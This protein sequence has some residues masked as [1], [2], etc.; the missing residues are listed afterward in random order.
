MVQE[1]GTLEGER[2]NVIELKFLRNGN[3]KETTTIISEVLMKSG[4]SIKSY[5]RRILD[6]G[7]IISIKI[8]NVGGRSI[9]V[10]FK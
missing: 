3:F 7:N 6:D 8:D 2:M 4:E 1:S 10:G 9:D 5:L